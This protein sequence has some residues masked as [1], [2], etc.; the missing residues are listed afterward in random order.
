MSLVV[1][2]PESFQR[3]QR[4]LFVVPAAEIS[5]AADQNNWA[6]VCAGLRVNALSCIK[7]AE[8]GWAGASFSCCEILAALHLHP[9][10]SDISAD[11]ITLSKGHAAAMQYS[12]RFACGMI[13]S[14]LLLSYK[15]GPCG[16]LEAHADIRMDTGS[17]GQ[18]LSTCCAIACMN[19]SQRCVSQN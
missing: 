15:D 3:R 19:P 16:G 11:N 4:A 13:S 5:R 7:S 10:C 17:L 18:C 8:H 2:D 6:A 12:C 9:S 14:E 1:L